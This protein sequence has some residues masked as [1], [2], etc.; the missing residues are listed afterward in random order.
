M[1]IQ[2]ELNIISRANEGLTQRAIIATLALPLTCAKYQDITATGNQD[3]TLPDATTLL[4]GWSV[5]IKA[6]TG[7]EL[8]VKDG[9]ATP[10]TLQ[11]VTAGS[12]AFEFTL[13]DNGSDNGTWMITSLENSGTVVANRYVKPHNSTTDWGSPSAGYYTISTTEA[14]HGRGT[15]PSIT[16][17]KDVGS[18][19]LN[20]VLVKSVLQT[21]GDSTFLVPEDPNGRYAGKAVYI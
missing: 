4:N 13:I 18:G 16:F 1:D 9:G 10:S 7:G 21:N 6:E 5:I 3:V 20:Q 19:V 2:T 8:T 15:T 14:T 17:Y 11:V 12:I